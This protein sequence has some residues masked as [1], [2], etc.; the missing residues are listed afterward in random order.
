MEEKKNTFN[1]LSL[2]AVF[3]AWVIPGAGHYCMGRR[4]QGIIIFIVIGLTFWTG[5]AMGGVMTV[6]RYHEP[7]WFGGQMLTGVHGLASWHRHNEVCREMLN[8]DLFKREGITRFEVYYSGRTPRQQQLADEYLQ[9]RGM[10]LVAPADTPARAYS[11]VAGLL[12]L[13]CIFDCAILAFMGGFSQSTPT[14]DDE[15]AAIQQ[16]ADKC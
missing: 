10:A 15:P 16:E 4:M 6:D 12:N 11:G 14:K 13:L 5:I 8:D 1:P 7:L 2:A 9:K 3:L